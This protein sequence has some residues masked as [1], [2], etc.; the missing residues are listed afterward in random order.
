[1]LKRERLAIALDTHTNFF[2]KNTNKNQLK[3]AKDKR[4]QI[5]I[6]KFTPIKV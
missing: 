5:I 1:M 2:L 6:V 4:M 3:N